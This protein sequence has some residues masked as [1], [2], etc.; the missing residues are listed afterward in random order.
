VGV[1]I[2]ADCPGCG[3]VR[4]GPQDLTV[5]VCSGDG[6][7]AYTFGCAEC[8]AA[9]SH[10]ASR[11]VCELLVSAGVRQVEWHWPD[12]LADRGSG[13]ALTTDDLLD[14]HLLVQRDQDCD[15]A[16]GALIDGA[17]RLTG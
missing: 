6:S 11:D 14:F 15:E 12:E 9:V 10:A 17:D 4:L 2:K 8:G 3:V 13:P 16:I 1:V 5:R 7:G